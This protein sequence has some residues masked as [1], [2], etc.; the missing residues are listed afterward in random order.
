MEHLYDANELEKMLI[1]RASATGTPISTTFEL[2]P[3]CNL[4]CEMCYIRIPHHRLEELGGWRSLEEWKATALEMKK[5]GTLFV[6]L[7]GGEPLLYPHFIELY[8]FLKMEGFIL[9]INTNGTQITPEI[10]QL[11]KNQLPRRLNI[12]LYGASEDT[13]EKLCHNR[14]GFQQC[15]DALSLLKQ[16]NIPVKINMSIVKENVHEID[17]MLKIAEDFGFPVVTDAYMMCKSND[18]CQ[19]PRDIKSHRL[20]PKVAAKYAIKQKIYEKG[21]HFYSDRD[22][23]LKN[24]KFCPDIQK[25]PLGI[26][27]RAGETSCWVDFRGR[28]RPCGI[29]EQYAFSLK[30][31]SVQ[32]AWKKIQAIPNQVTPHYECMGCDLHDLCD[33][34]WANACQEKYVNGNLNYLCEMTKEIFKLLTEGNF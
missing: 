33:V 17:S 19:P 31:Y 30:D 24:H 14:S 29:I 20:D 15:L 7:T 28:L 8:T 32:E 25:E 5:M 2:T 4:K 11:F 3:T 18:V 27:C 6:L 12:T 34:C 13:Y 16:Y 1:R 23:L 10:A 26:T 21:E 22:I 9:T